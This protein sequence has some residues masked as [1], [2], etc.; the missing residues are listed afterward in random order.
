[1]AVCNPCQEFVATDAADLVAV[2]A[3]LDGIGYTVGGE[4]AT[5][6]DIDA[7]LTVRIEYPAWTLV[8]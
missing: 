3:Y 8:V 2:K 7:S 1:M 6:T 5:R 4:F